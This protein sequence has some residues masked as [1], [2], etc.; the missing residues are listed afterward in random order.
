MYVQ[1][2]LLTYAICTYNVMHFAPPARYKSTMF[3]H[4]KFAIY[5][6]LLILIFL[7]IFYSYYAS[8]TIIYSYFSYTYHYHII[9]ILHQEP[10][11]RKS[12]WLSKTQPVQ[13]IFADYEQ[14]VIVMLLNKCSEYESESKKKNSRHLNS[15]IASLKLIGC[16]L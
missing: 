10:L 13:C 9:M 7:N 14:Y 6:M 11:S 2:I 15:T 3:L 4:C 8:E 1:L 5:S 12:T 16:T